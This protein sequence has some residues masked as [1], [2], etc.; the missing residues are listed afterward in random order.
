MKRDGCRGEEWIDGSMEG[1]GRGWD[2]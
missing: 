1:D 2:E